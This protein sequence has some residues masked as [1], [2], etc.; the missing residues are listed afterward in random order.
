MATETIFLSLVAGTTELHLADNQG[1]SGN[2]ITTD[3]NPGDDV[4]WKTVGNSGISSIN[5]IYKKS[6]QSV[7]SSGPSAQTATFW[8]G[9]VSE[10]ATGQEVYGIKYT[11]N[12]VEYDCDPIIKVKQ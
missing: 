10:S 4:Q 11:V 12:G 5:S 3:V 9:T 8:K 2:N 6:S 7:F 1:H